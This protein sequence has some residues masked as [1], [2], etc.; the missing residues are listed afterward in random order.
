MSSQEDLSLVKTVLFNRFPVVPEKRVKD[1]ED[2]LVHRHQTGVEGKE[3]STLPLALDEDT[4]HDSYDDR[5]RLGVD[6]VL[7]KPEL[8]FIL[9]EDVERCEDVKPHL[10]TEVGVHDLPVNVIETVTSAEMICFHY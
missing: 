8:I 3:G 9:N 1:K 7:S 2:H 10:A 5:H 4:P 6:C